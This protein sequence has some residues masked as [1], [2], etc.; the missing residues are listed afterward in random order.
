MIDLFEGSLTTPGDGE[1][2]GAVGS[3]KGLEQ[4]LQPLCEVCDLVRAT[5]R[6][7]FSLV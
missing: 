2:H 3:A 1:A 7:A 6:T 5:V 4:G